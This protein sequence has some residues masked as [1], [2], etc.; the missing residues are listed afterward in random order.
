MSGTYKGIQDDKRY[1]GE[2]VDVTFNLKRCIHAAECL[3]GLPRVFNRKVRPWVDPARAEADAITA[4]V[5]RCPSGA[6]HV[7]R[8]DGGA[9][10]PIPERNI[11]TVQTNGYLRISGNL[12]IQATGVDIAQE[13]RATL[14]RCGASQ[15]KPFCDNSHLEINFQAPD[16]HREAEIEAA[17][18]VPGEFEPGGVLHITAKPNGSLRLEGNFEVYSESGELIYRGTRRSLCRCG[19]SADKPFCDGTHREIGFKED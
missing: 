15:A 6:L 3:R 1:T 14:C 2:Q 10:E 4:V 8:K 11:V 19:G 13:T 7:E 18:I 12:A 16:D 9:G 5:V 17:E